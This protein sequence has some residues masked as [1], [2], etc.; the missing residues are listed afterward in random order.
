MKP[1][2][3][4]WEWKYEGLDWVLI[5]P[6]GLILCGEFLEIRN[7]LTGNMIEFNPDVPDA[8]LIAAAP[9]LLE[10]VKTYLAHEDELY[11]SQESFIAKELIARI[12]EKS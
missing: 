8:K 12:E 7:D 10:I 3:G 9:E 11:P 4:R 2:P 1:T 6:S 5:S